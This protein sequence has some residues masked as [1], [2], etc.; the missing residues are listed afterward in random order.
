MEVL[1]DQCM[2]GLQTPG[3]GWRGWCPAQKKTRFLTI[4]PWIAHELARRCDGSHTHQQL[5]GGRANDAAK[6]PLALCQAICRGLVEELRC[7]TLGVRGV[8][9]ILPLSHVQLVQ[10]SDVD[11]LEDE[12]Q[13]KAL[14]HEAWE[15]VSGM[16]LDP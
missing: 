11:H 15:N 12:E 10:K 14:L 5:L 16:P 13:T 2:F 6:Y 4:S 1:I 3:P 7:K 8:S 9:E